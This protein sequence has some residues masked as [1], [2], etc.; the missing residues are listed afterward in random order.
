MTLGSGYTVQR[1]LSYPVAPDGK[2]NV[3]YDSFSSQLAWRQLLRL[4]DDEELM[5]PR[6][7]GGGPQKSRAYKEFRAFIYQGQRY[8]E[9]AERTSGA[10]SAL[11][12]YYAFLNLAKA[13]LLISRGTG[14][15]NEQVHHGLTAPNPRGISTDR[16]G[17]RNGVFRW[18]YRD[19]LGH[20]PPE[21]TVPVARV[22]GNVAA[23]GHEI[24]FTRIVALK[25]LGGWH[26]VAMDEQRMWS[27]IAFGSREVG[28][29]SSPTDRRIKEHFDQIEPP[30]NWREVFGVSNRYASRGLSVFQ[31]KFEQDISHTGDNLRIEYVVE[32]IRSVWQAL[33]PVIDFSHYPGLDFFLCPHLYRTR[34]FPMPTSLA[35]YA[36]LFYVSSLVRYAPSLVDPHEHPE[37]AWLLA[38][39]PSETAPFLLHSAV[40]RILGSYLFYVSPEAMRS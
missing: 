26:T 38:S 11:P 15:L 28:T 6:F 20:I 16:L 2:P 5:R 1:W 8:Y 10:P 35:A 40:N 30:R 25:V 17:I 14:F 29:G 4:A 32:Q 22:L 13:E 23:I 36:A 27:L 33:D 7:T 9:A 24:S 31:S 39:V 21:S 18:L 37:Q 3:L 12:Y 19:R 34:E